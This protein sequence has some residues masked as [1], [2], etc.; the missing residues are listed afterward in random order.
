M[1]KPKSEPVGAETPTALAAREED[2]LR[3]KIR[4][5]L[6]KEKDGWKQEFISALDDVVGGP[7]RDRIPSDKKD[8]PAG[9]SGGENL[10]TDDWNKRQDRFQYS[11][12]RDM[13]D[14]LYSTLPRYAQ[15]IRNPK[16]DRHM[17]E[18]LRGVRWR[19]WTKVTRTYQE[20][21]DMYRNGRA[22]A[23]GDS[24][25]EAGGTPGSGAPFLPLP[26]ANLIVMARDAR[27]KIRGVAQR[28]TSV[29]QSL[30]VPTSGV[31]TAGMVGEGATQAEATPT[32]ASILLTKKKAQAR[33]RVSDEMLEDSAFNLVS[34]FAERGGSALGALEDV[35]FSTSNGTAP[36]ITES[37]ESATITPFAEA[38]ATVMTYVD[39]VGLFFALPEQYRVLGCFWMGNSFMMQ[40]LSSIVDANGRPIFTPGFNAPTVVTSE[41]PP[42]G[43]VG[44]IFGH[45][46]LELPLTEGTSPQDASLFVGVMNNYGYLDGG[47]ITVR[48]SEHIRWNEDEVEWK[49]TERIDGAVLLADSFREML[50]IASVA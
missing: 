43:T 41:A 18:F 28:F 15:R 23:E 30:K 48:A 13:S 45:P 35:Q 47:G 49:V 50:G 42:L 38:S 22:L 6:N 19:D 31:A 25:L 32:L 21:N 29:G 2:E 39:V 1:P 17:A 5:T 44:T 9:R 33:F 14:Y 16:T 36:N 37:L 11:D 10:D 46:V 7:N 20:L 3:Q 24:E 4:K 12:V 27:A 34:Y 26:L 8:A 40:L